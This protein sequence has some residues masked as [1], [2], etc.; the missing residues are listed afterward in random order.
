MAW[1]DVQVSVDAGTNTDGERERSATGATKVGDVIGAD[2][3]REK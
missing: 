3:M 2:K 1:S